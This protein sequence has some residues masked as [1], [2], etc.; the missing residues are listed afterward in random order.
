VKGYWQVFMVLVVAAVIA[1]AA[2]QVADTAQENYSPVWEN[3]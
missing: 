1:A 2:G 3:K